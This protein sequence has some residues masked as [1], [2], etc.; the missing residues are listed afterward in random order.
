MSHNGPEPIKGYYSSYLG[1]QVKGVSVFGRAASMVQSGPL[2]G[3]LLILRSGL[4][5][6]LRASLRA[7]FRACY[8]SSFTEFHKGCTTLRS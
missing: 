7:P 2:Q 4:R 6:P 8:R 1:V 5:A 3:V